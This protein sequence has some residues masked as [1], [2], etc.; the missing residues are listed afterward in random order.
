MSHG[1]WEGHSRNYHII[2]GAENGKESNRDIS[3]YRFLL[4]KQHQHHRLDLHLD[5]TE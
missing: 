3:N 2:G 4:V 1:S 5:S